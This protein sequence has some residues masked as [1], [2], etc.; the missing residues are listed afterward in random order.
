MFLGF[1]SKSNCMMQHGASLKVLNVPMQSQQTL[2]EDL[3]KKLFAFNLKQL[4][5]KTS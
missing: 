4:G 5:G 1:H 3:T 2:I